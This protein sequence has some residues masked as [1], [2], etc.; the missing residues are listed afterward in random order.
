[1]GPS[2]RADNDDAGGRGSHPLFETRLSYTPAA[3]FPQAGDVKFS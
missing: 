1:M 2:V 3:G